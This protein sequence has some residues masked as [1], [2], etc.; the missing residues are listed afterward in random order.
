MRP[1]PRSISIVVPVYNEQDN[2]AVLY[3]RLLS[4]LEN[5]ADDVEI[6]FVDDGSKD[7]SLPLISSLAQADPRVRFISFSR[8][9]GHEAA[10]TA[11]LRCASGE[12][13]VL[14]DAD[15]QDPPELIPELLA[16]WRQGFDVVYAVRKH[17][18]NESWV[19]RSTSL[20]FY[21]IINSLSNPRLPV[22]TGDFRLIDRKALDALKQCREI[23]RFVRGLS[24]WV[25]F[26]QVGVPYDRESRHGG[27]TKYNYIK[28]TLLAMDAISSF[29][30]APLRLSLIVGMLG[31]LVGA[32][33]S[34]RL[35]LIKLIWDV[36]I[37]GYTFQT[38]SI[39]FFG[40][41]NFVLLG[42]VAVYLGKVFVEVQGRPLYII[43]DQSPSLNVDT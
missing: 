12:V 22:D 27:K 34:I 26:R 4:V 41:L 31:F 6:I 33:L 2:V 30:L 35:L 24:T 17:R 23:S 5:L 40:S 19:K 29:S 14:I 39:L 42:I 32:I 16:Q 38:L 21:R 10:S 9:F 36:P 7:D 1:S 43:R 15:L 20:I 28:L 37:P 11:G 25:G 13:T 8:N 3:G 18:E